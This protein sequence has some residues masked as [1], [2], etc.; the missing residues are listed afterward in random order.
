VQPSSAWVVAL[1]KIELHL[2]LE[3]AMRPSTVCD[4]TLDRTETGQV[5]LP[6]W[7]ETYYT[8]TDFD[9]FMTQLTPRFPVYPSEYARIAAEC[10][11]DL[12]KQQVVYAEVSFDA[13]V[14]EAGEVD[15]YWSIVEE[16]E[17]ER[18][19]AESRWPIRLNLI[20]GIQRRFGLDV[21]VLRVELAARAR[22]R[23]IGIVGIDLHGHE[24]LYPGAVF[25]PAYD[26][27]RALGLGLRAH[28]G[29]ADGV[30]SVWDAINLLGVR[31][32]AHG[33]RALED[34]AL[35]E[36]LQQGDVV[37]EICPTS[38]VRTGVVPDLASHPFRRLYELGVAVTVNSDDP[39]PFFTTIEREYRLLVDEFGFTLDELRAITLNAARAAF[40]SPEERETLVARIESAYRA[41]ARATGE[42]GADAGAAPE[43]ASGPHPF[44][45]GQ[46]M[47]ALPGK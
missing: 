37:L 16:L 29:E 7:E 14:R 39:L 30:Q 19:K 10:F 2:H 1:P 31:R 36:R 45:E 28:A 9:G 43:R 17:E 46:D 34:P 4:L 26:R 23:G 47:P 27:A 38:N 13:P 20:S 35:I 22:D 11:E 25:A 8:Y 33:I 3:G 12:A 18:R 24:G 32:I 5:L 40:L 44:K 21:A 6:G 41:T 15:R 42:V